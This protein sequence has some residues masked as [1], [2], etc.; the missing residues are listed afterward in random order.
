M[1][2][3]ATSTCVGLSGASISK[4]KATVSSWLHHNDI[5]Q[6][7]GRSGIRVKC[8]HYNGVLR[9]N[10]EKLVYILYTSRAIR[11]MEN[12]ENAS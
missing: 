3:F 9:A 7:L 11:K 2:R 8:V 1:H 4:R 6:N 5:I 12:V 10:A